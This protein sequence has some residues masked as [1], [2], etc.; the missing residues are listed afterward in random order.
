MFFKKQ[1]LTPIQI[2]ERSNIVQIDDMGYPLV[3]CIMSDNSQRWVDVDLE[4]ARGEIENGNLKVL[5]WEKKGC[6]CD[7]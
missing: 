4:W 7:Q 3:L 1:N 5:E 2:T 6:E